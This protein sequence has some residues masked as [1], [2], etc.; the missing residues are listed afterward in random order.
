MITAFAV[1]AAFVALLVASYTDIRTRE[2]PDWLSFALIAVGIGSRLILSA[3]SWDPTW[4]VQGLL[5]LA[6][7]VG[8]GYLM[9]YTGQW[10]GGDSK[11]LMGLGA[12]LGLTF[13]FS[14]IYISLLVNIL[15]VG[16]LYGFTWSLVMAVR[17]WKR[18]AKKFLEH[19]ALKAFVHSRWMAMALIAV[20]ITASFIS[21]EQTFS[22]LYLILAVTIF[23]L[24]YLW[25][26]VKAVEEAVMLKWVA[27][28]V[29]TEGDWIAEEV[30][31]KGKVITGP[32]D[33]GI[34]KEQIARLKRLKVR[35]VL[36]KEGIPFVPSFLIAFIFTMLFGNAVLLVF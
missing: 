9:F 32:K 31:V 7:G 27:P 22:M 29:L 3:A 36:I 14:D 19:T 18:F 25:V 4:I 2:V 20:L 5:G 24:L 28:S 1:T 26:F 21:G 35:K 33:L 10:G 12:T 23:V 13:S 11:L 15:F 16:A 6:L 34:S 8:L 17:N 30:K